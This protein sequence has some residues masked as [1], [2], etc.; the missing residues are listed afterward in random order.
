MTEAAK[1]SGLSFDYIWYFL[2]CIAVNF[3]LRIT[4]LRLANLVSNNLRNEIEYTMNRR[5]VQKMMQLPLS[6]HE[7]HHTGTKIPTISRAARAVG[8]YLFFYYGVLIELFVTVVGTFLV[9]ATF[10][11]L[12]I[13]HFA[14]YAVLSLSSLIFIR[15]A[16]KKAVREKQEVD[17]K[18]SAENYEAL[19]NVHTVFAAGAFRAINQRLEGLNLRG[20]TQAKRLVWLNQSRWFAYNMLW[21][22]FFVLMLCI[23]V[24][25]I[26]AGTMAI[27]MLASLTFYF[28]NIDQ[29]MSELSEGIQTIMTSSVSIEQYQELFKGIE[30]RSN[31]ELNIAP[32]WKKLCVENI[33][34][35]YGEKK[36]LHGVS[37]TIARGE[38]VGI[39]G[40]S[41]SGKS[42]FL[43]ILA[44]LRPAD[45]GTVRF[46]SI[47]FESISDDDFRAKV[48]VALQDTEV[49]QY[50]FAENI[51]LSAPQINEESYQKL[52]SEPWVQSIIVRLADG[53]QTL[54]GEKG[55]KL[56]GGERQR[57]GIARALIK[58][59]ELL[60]LDEATSHLDSLTE[61]EVQA[62]IESLKGV[63]VVAVAHRLS[64]LKNFD[65]IFVM[66]AGKIIEEG[67]WDELLQKNGAFARLKQRQDKE[68][69]IR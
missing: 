65:R 67:A 32:D 30:I 56:S 10:D 7:T 47:G 68:N 14:L 3:V 17:N 22:T 41:G 43:S 15:R 42:S 57:L 5:S 36:V 9:V 27:G 4:C 58:Q 45:K 53:D 31:G 54:V 25:A 66:E 44:H 52:L 19:H 12:F 64:T 55:V 33:H 62:T 8:D 40:V 1:G 38:K 34:L 16:L 37:M 29:T 63:T 28:R 2:G 21:I 26:S 11:V 51:R 61:T 59:P 24:P 69:A 35:Q 13:G 20:L 48:G 18:L 49:F 50:S 6:W 23:A 39:V 46:D 60:L